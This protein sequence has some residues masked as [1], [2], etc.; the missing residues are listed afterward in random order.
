LIVSDDNQVFSNPIPFPFCLM[1][2]CEPKAKQSY[3]LVCFVAPLLAMTSTPQ[4]REMVL[5]E[6]LTPLLNTLYE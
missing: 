2:H 6:G 4:E 1:C 3:L 5:E